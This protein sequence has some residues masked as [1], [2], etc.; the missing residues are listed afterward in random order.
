[1][2][3]VWIP[4]LVVGTAKRFRSEYRLLY[5]RR[6][7]NPSKVLAQLPLNVTVVDIRLGKDKQI[8]YLFKGRL[9]NQLELEQM[10]KE[11]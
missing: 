4:K 6:T 9:P 7:T 5:A 10:W 1:M 8:N 2:D 11:R 3:N